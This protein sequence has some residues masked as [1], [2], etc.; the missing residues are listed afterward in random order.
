MERGDI[1]RHEMGETVSAR[2]DNL[3]STALRTRTGTASAS[4]GRWRARLRYHQDGTAT[5]YVEHHG[6]TMVIAHLDRNGNAPPDK[7]VFDLG[8][9]S[10]SDQT[11]VNKVI[12][13]I[14]LGRVFYY[15]R[16]QRG[17]GPRIT[18]R[19]GQWN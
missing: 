1:A 16:D 5:V 6:T 12:R 2:I 14:G 10:K 3:V 19:G 17:G 11:G 8:W 13:D 4:S 18:R 15:S 9:G 7:V